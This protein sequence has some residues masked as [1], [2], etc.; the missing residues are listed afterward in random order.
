MKK[1][2]DLA[3]GFTRLINNRRLQPPIQMVFNSSSL[4]KSGNSFNFSYRPNN[5]SCNLQAITIRQNFA[6]PSLVI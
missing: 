2:D 3:D 6:N 4:T 1:K 5:C